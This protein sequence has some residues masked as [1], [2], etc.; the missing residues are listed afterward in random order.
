M[1]SRVVR[2]PDLQSKIAGLKIKT[3]QIPQLETE[4]VG[5]KEETARIPQLDKDLHERNTTNA[6]LF[7]SNLQQL[8]ARRFTPNKRAPAN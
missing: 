2:Q 4:I 6:V 3:A 1:R 8:F 5:L 7:K